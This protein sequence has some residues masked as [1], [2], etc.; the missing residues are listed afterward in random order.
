MKLNYTS[1]DGKMNVELE[2]SSQKE[3]FKELAAFQEV[4]EQTECSAVID[5]KLHKSNNTVFRVRIV[6]DNDYCEL[7]CVEPGPL[8]M[9]KKIFGQAKKGGGLFPKWPD[10]ED[11]N[12]VLGN[13]GWH[14]WVGGQQ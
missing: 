12:I 8:F 2:G 3:L 13:N 11:K 4:F 7:V 1:R 10:R 6:D 14:R 9:Y 5:G